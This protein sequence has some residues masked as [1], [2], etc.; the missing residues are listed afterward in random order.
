MIKRISANFVISR[1]IET[2]RPGS[3]VK[4]DQTEPIKPKHSVFGIQFEKR[5]KPIG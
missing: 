1:R 2:T 5:Y 3:S 4:T